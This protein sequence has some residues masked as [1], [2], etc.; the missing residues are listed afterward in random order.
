MKGEITAQTYASHLSALMAKVSSMDGK[1]ANM[2]IKIFIKE[3]GSSAN[4]LELI[5]QQSGNTANVQSGNVA[6][7]NGNQLMGGVIGDA[8]GG[9]LNT[10][11]WTLVGDRPGGGFVNG[12]SELISPTGYVYDAKTSKQLMDSGMLGAVQS[13]AISGEIGGGGGAVKNRFKINT[14]SGIMTR[15]GVKRSTIEN[16][17][18]MSGADIVASNEQTAATTAQ[19]TLQMQQQMQNYINQQIAGQQQGFEMLAAV[20]IGENPRAVGAAVSGEFAKLT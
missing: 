20:L 8:A 4:A 18:N 12:V 11:G 13:R 6:S 19:Q 2:Y 7:Q 3:Y 10:G 17:L 5:S 14:G 9:P 1:T 16:N 15:A